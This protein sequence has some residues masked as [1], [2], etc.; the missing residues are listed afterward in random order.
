MSQRTYN[1]LDKKLGFRT[2]I[3]NANAPIYNVFASIYNVFCA[4]FTIY[5][6]G[7]AQ[8]P[9]VF[10]G[11]K[12]GAKNV[13]NWRENVVNW[14]KHLVNSSSKFKFFERGLYVAAKLSAKRSINFIKLLS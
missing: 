2:P 1:S 10:L 11:C 9:A 6:Y 4:N 14:R 12:I 7:G 13:V 3:Y 8:R 5:I